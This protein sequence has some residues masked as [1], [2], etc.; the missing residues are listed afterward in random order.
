MDIIYDRDEETSDILVSGDEQIMMEWEKPYMEACISHL[1]PIGD[2][3]EIGFGFGYSARQL[4][5]YEG[6]TSYTV[7][8]CEP[9]V[10]ERYE[11]VKVEMQQL[12]PDI[13]F[14]IMKGRWETIID[15]MGVYDTIFF[16]DF[17][18]KKYKHLQTYD[19]NKRVPLFIY[20]C[21]QDHTRLGSKISYYLSKDTNYYSN[22]QCI[23]SKIISYQYEIPENCNYK[24]GNRIMH[25]PLLTK[26]KETEEE[27]YETYIQPIL[28]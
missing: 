24:K 4:C 20:K 18:Y 8:E 22:L 10:W 17:P 19:T 6:V 1:K 9:I 26:I 13:K 5:S 21:L 12:Y 28:S 3:L 27:F 2:V 23:D 11:Q 15:Y 25:V 7:I 16:D 14:H